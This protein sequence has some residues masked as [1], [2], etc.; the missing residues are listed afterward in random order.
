LSI[1]SFKLLEG[2]FLLSDC[3]SADHIHSG[4]VPSSFFR[5]RHQAE[6]V[7]QIWRDTSDVIRGEVYGQL[8]LMLDHPQDVRNF[9]A[10]PLIS[11]ADKASDLLRFPQYNKKISIALT[12]KTEKSHSYMCNV[13]W[14]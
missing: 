11:N 8:I 7:D 14:L 5:V 3:F 1:L 10:A 13:K 6:S 4:S 9:S 2:F 12:R